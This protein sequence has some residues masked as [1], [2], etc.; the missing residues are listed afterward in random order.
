M[1]GGGGK[2]R[3]K[4]GLL[5]EIDSHKYIVIPA[6]SR[7]SYLLHSPSVDDSSLNCCCLEG[8][9]DDLLNLVLEGIICS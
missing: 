6:P 1:G 8:C 2:R 5:R 9:C 7:S 4:R 3:R